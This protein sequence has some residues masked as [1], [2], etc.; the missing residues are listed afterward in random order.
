MRCK[1]APLRNIQIFVKSNN[2]SALHGEKFKFF[3]KSSNSNGEKTI[4]LARKKIGK[5]QIFQFPETTS[6]SCPLR[7]VDNCCQF[8]FLS[9]KK[10]VEFQFLQENKENKNKLQSS[11]KIFNY[12]AFALIFVCRSS[13]FSV[14][15]WLIID[16][17]ATSVWNSP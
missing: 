10:L 6:S 12:L 7:K 9:N 5:K 15:F 13:T 4:F 1:C 3:E 2:A 8:V 14:I 11:E 17:S 16:R